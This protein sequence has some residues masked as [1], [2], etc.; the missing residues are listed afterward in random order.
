MS[1][2]FSEDQ[3]ALRTAAR[4]LFERHGGPEAL[5]QAW[6]DGSGR[7]PGLWQQLADQGLLAVMVPEAAGGLGLG[8]V[9]MVCLQQEAGR[10]ACPEPFLETCLGA[11]VIDDPGLAE[12]QVQLSVASEEHPLFLHGDSADLLLSIE[13]G[14][15]LSMEPGAVDLSL[16]SSV[17]RS[18]RL[19]ALMPG[20]TGQALEG[21]TT[22]LRDHGRLFAAA[23]VLGLSQRL[24]EMTVDF[25][26]NRAQFGRS[27]GSFQAVS[28]PL[29]DL[30]KELCFAEPLLYEAAWRLDQKEDAASASVAMAKAEISEAALTA[31]EACLQAHGAMGYSYEYDLQLYLKRAWALARCW[32]EPRRLRAELANSLFDESESP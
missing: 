3:E 14:A 1:F 32:G 5:R 2:A 19:F 25:V 4:E 22:G 9:E 28:H 11:L 26:S 20:A 24:L 7:I 21:D 31:C 17:D 10:A 6:T 16:Q 29:V 13:D 30:A 18:R 27:I 23:Q 12:G 8:A 15:L